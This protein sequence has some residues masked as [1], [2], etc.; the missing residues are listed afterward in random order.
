MSCTK[1][2]RSVRAVEQ[3]V[4]DLVVA[5]FTRARLQ[6]IFESTDRFSKVTVEVSHSMMLSEMKALKGQNNWAES[7]T[8]P[9]LEIRALVAV[10]VRKE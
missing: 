4:A 10:G 7:V 8:G 9:D 3:A 2:V 5:G 6:E 1:A